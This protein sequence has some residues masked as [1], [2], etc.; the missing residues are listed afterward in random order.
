MS[1]QRR[2]NKQ[3]S[4]TPKRIFESMIE[5]ANRH[6]L[7]AMAAYFA[8]DY[9][10][11]LP[12]SP[13]GNFIGQAGVRK[14]WSAF[15]ST[16][17]DFQV[18]ILSEA[19]EGSTVWAELFFHGTRADGAEQMMQGVSIMEIQAEKIARGK[20]YQSLVRESPGDGA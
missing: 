8:H 5:A 12:F 15:F 3:S 18:K 19:V 11:E 17:P 1:E 2:R 7:E 4:P 14:N 20:L 9:R 16:M 6:D 10:G 13:E